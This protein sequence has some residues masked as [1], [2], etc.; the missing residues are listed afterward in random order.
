M[1]LQH[2]RWMWL[3]H[4]NNVQVSDLKENHFLELLDNNFHPIQPTYTRNGAWLK[5]IGFSNSLCVRATRAITSHAPIGKF[6]IRFFPK[7]DFS[8]PCGSYPIE[9]RWY[10]LHK[11]RRYNNYWNPNRESF[12]HFVAFLELILGHFSSMEESLVFLVLS[13]CSTFPFLL[14]FFSL[15]FAFSLFFSLC[16]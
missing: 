12:S 10:I 14:S 15:F 5:T 4:S 13:L 9:S 7:E 2:K 1:R 16:K 8:C 11:C 6:Y 3:D